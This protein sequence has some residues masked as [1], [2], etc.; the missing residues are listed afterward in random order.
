MKNFSLII[1]LLLF[2]IPSG[3]QSQVAA[4]PDEAKSKQS[5]LEEFSG[6]SGQ[7]LEKKFLRIG[8]FGQTSVDVL[9]ITDMN[10]KKVVS[11]VRLERV[12]STQYTSRTI[13]AFIDDDEV[14]GAIK[15]MSYLKA[16]ILGSAIPENYTEYQFV[17]RSGF[18]VGCFNEKKDWIG[19]INIDRIGRD[20]FDSFNGVRMAELQ[21]LFEAAKEKLPK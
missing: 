12:V 14:D 8:K 18:Q 13:S 7:L 9:I 3:C 15:S 20:G 19:F 11:G 16:Q 4:K 5:K 1:F 10:S 17:S 2:T 6:R 21:T